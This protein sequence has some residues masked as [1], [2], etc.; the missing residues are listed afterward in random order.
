MNSITSLIR[1]S[2]R[3]Y[4]DG[5]KRIMAAPVSSEAIQFYALSVTFGCRRLRR[6]APRVGIGCS[7]GASN[8]DRYRGATETNSL[9]G[10]IE[11]RRTGYRAE[12]DMTALRNITEE[13]SPVFC[14]RHGDGRTSS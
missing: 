10:D 11:P 9:L 7:N 3:A 2:K 13:L 5:S 1:A 4:I 6:Y 12:S 8:R 14:A